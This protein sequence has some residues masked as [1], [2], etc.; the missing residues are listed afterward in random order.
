MCGSSRPSKITQTPFRQSVRS[1]VSSV[2]VLGF[3]L[4]LKSTLRSPPP[5]R[6]PSPRG[7]PGLTHYRVGGR[8][9][10][11]RVPESSRVVSREVR[12]SIITLTTRSTPTAP[13]V[14]TLTV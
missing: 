1:V 10:H 6:P 13:V 3:S 8:V 5:V 14:L 2:T 12:S 9:R 11:L 7:L 4:S